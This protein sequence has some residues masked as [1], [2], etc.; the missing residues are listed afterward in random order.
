MIDAPRWMAQHAGQLGRLRL[1]QL[2]LPGTHDSGAYR[3]HA[4][5]PVSRWWKDVLLQTLLGCVRPCVAPWTITQDRCIR[6][7][8]E[9]GSRYFDLRLAFSPEAGVCWLA[10]TFVAVP[11]C[12]ALSC[13]AAFLVEQPG[14]VVVLALRP[15]WEHRLA[16]NAT[17]VQAACSELE[18]TCGAWLC[19]QPPSGEKLPTLSQAVACGQR[20]VVFLEGVP[21]ED[22]PDPRPAGV[23][24]HYGCRSVWPDRTDADAAVREL[25][26]Q[27]EALRETGQLYD[28]S[29]WAASAAATPTPLSVVA[30]AA[31]CRR[32]WGLRALAAAVEQQLLLPGVLGALAGVQAVTVDFISADVMG[33]IVQCNLV[34]ARMAA[35][36]KHHV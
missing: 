25:L 34:R 13:V 32:P 11:F 23:W 1:D 26:R 3:L 8:L 36:T 14:E 35:S 27:V 20:L 5:R 28:G 2:M 17:A 22:L 15:D 18:R 4:G 31:D 10:H 9:A 29:W 24:C 21:D 30:A 6:A 19:V 12:E 33:A 16:F 7:Q